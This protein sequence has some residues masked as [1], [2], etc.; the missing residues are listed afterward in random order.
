MKAWENEEA[1]Q[2]WGIK[3]TF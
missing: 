2:T 3:Y 1:P